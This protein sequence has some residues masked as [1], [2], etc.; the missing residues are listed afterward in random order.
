M[1]LSLK[2]FALIIALLGGFATAQQVSQVATGTPSFASFGGGPFDSVNLGNL[3]M[4]FTIPI[5]HKAGRGVPFSFDL[6]YDSSIWNPV[7]SN[8][9]TQW[10]PTPNFGWQTGSPFGYITY[11]VSS[12]TCTYQ[13]PPPYIG[14][15]VLAYTVYQYQNWTFVD[16]AGTT[17]PFAL[18][19]PGYT[20]YWNGGTVA[21]TNCSAVPTTYPSGTGT[22]TDGTSY[23]ISIVNV[24]TPTVTARNGTQ[25]GQ[26]TFIDTNGNKISSNNSGQYFDTLSSTVPVLTV[27]GT[28]PSPTTFTYTAPSGAQ[29]SYR[30]NYV[31]YTVATAFGFGADSSPIREYGPL[32]KYLVDTI[33]LPDGTEYKFSYEAGPSGCALQNGTSSC[34]TGR[35]A[36]LTLPTGGAITYTPYIGGLH[37]TGINRDGSTAG[38]TRMLS[39]TASCA[40]TIPTGC[41]QYLRSLTGSGTPGPGSTWTTTVTDPVGNQ[42]FMNFVEDSTTTT[43]TTTATYSMYETQRQV[44]QGTISS[45]HI[46]LTTNACYNTNFTNCNTA[47]VHSPIT[48][49]DR[50]AQPAGGSTRLT[51]TTFNSSGLVTDTKEYDYGAVTGAAPGNTNLIRETVT[52]YASLGNNILNRPASTIVYDWSSGSQVKIASNTYGYDQT[53]VT[54]TSGTPQ[55]VAVSGSR[56]NVTTIT[57][58][59]NSTSTLTKTFTYYDTGTPKVA[60]DVIGA[61]TTFVYGTT[62]QGN[63]TISCGNSFVTTINEPLGLSRAITWNCTGGVSTQLQDENLNYTSADYSTD[64]NFWRPASVTDQMNNQSTLSYSPTSVESALQNFNGGTSASDSL[65]T[66]DGFGRPVFGQR[67]QAPGSSNYDTVE[68]D[69]NNLGQPYRFTMPYTALAS[70]SS[71]NTTIAATT[72]TYDALGRVLTIIDGGGGTVNY[73]YTANDVLQKVSGTPNGTQAFQKQFEYDGLGRLRSVCEMS[74]TLPGVGTCAQNT[75]QTGYWTKYTYDALGHLL[76]VA[77][78]AQVTTGQQN[79]SFTYDWLGRLMTETNPESGLMT[80]IYDTATSTCGSGTAPGFLVE[81]VDNAGVHTCYGI[82]L[83]GRVNH[84]FAAGTN[85]GCKNFIY[86][87]VSNNGMPIQNGKTRVVEAVL[88]LNCNGGHDIDE[89]FSYD[90]RGQVTDVWESTPHSG[91]YYHTTAGYWAN[92]ALNTLSL[93]NSSGAALIPQITYKLDSEGRTNLVNAASGQN[94]VTNVT[95]SPGNSNGPLGTLEAVRFGSADND[96][97]TW[98][99]NT[100]R[101]KSYNFNVNSSADKGTL[102][103]S[104]NG[105]LTKLVINDQIPGT[106][107]SQ[108]CTYGYDDVQRVS[109]VTCGTFWVQNFTYDSFGNISKNVP[110]GDG[111]LSFLPTYWT[112]PP[113]NQFSAIPGIPAPYY[114]AKGNLTKDNL[115]TYTWDGFGQMA[116]ATP[117]GGSTVSVTYDALGRMV[118]NNAGGSYT[119]FVYGPSGKIAKCNGQTLVKAFVSLPGGAKAIYT[120]AWL[121]YYRHS[122][123]LGSS[124]LT[125]TA[126]RTMYSSAAYAPF[127]EQ[128]ATYP[129]VGAADASYTG[130]DSDTVSSLYDFPARRQSSSQGRW[131]SPDPAG[132]AAVVLTNPQSWNRYAYVNNNP[133]RLIDSSGLCG[134]EVAANR[135]GVQAH[136]ATCDPPTDGGG[137][138]SGAG[139]DGGAGGGDAGGGDGGNDSGGLG[140]DPGCSDANC[141]T[142]TAPDPSNDPCVG[143]GA[144]IDTNMDNSFLNSY[145]AQTGAAVAF[146]YDSSVGEGGGGGIAGGLESVATQAFVSPNGSTAVMANF[147]QNL[148]TANKNV[149]LVLFSGGAQAFN[150]AVASGAITQ[151]NLNSISQIIYVSPG[152]PGGFVSTGIPTQS[153]VGNLLNPTEALVAG[154][155]GGPYPDDGAP[156]EIPNCGHRLQCDIQSGDIVQLPTSSNC[157]SASVTGKNE[158]PTLPPTEKFNPGEEA[159][160]EY[161]KAFV[162]GEWEVILNPVT[163]SSD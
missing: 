81:K 18:A 87:E 109:N 133:L 61:Q 121:Q 157:N 108:T 30:M 101:M 117:S 4:H 98:D 92:G 28:A 139:G 27:S 160:A 105:T 120:T 56:G 151:D 65:S 1:K 118:E 3:N 82:D 144:G 42:S 55:H 158:E 49:T 21:N 67:L 40:G 85:S 116:T 143:I 6:A 132:R 37:G 150:T 29:A 114:D 59:S 155:T 153:Y 126:S 152:A 156:T 128:Y 97:F 12:W 72:R 154:T 11:S 68:T 19:S 63:S 64:A 106:S 159:L 22:S 145:S 39:P 90:K 77:Q 34:V 162:L 113:T 20:S 25:V 54:G 7:T 124:R 103:W 52:T 26:T 163:G 146:P 32:A 131:I 75:A 33:Q 149:V 71:Q 31:N 41:W 84:M 58:S 16:R 125:S 89:Y 47:S 91:G 43:A 95:Y 122:D 57:T 110:P 24:S 129:S 35:I 136:D 14:P 99:N 69:Y 127:G 50:Y 88:D 70:P 112:S 46:L 123:W 104:A 134:E 76:T 48:K 141:V 100:G 45:G 137:G 15:P 147:V 135:G 66:V 142:V 60:T 111:G 140:I 5:L 17:H 79:R 93:L 83:L 96:V 38:L 115:N 119:E 78:N 36:S 94:P 53:G 148:T 51:E 74:G 10:T 130:Q 161:D 80:Y 86:G 9:V 62:P 23:L 102:T 107:D 2:Q 44:Y 8:G 138:D 13:P 73:T